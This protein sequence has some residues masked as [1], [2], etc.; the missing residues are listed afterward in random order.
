MILSCPFKKNDHV[1][2]LVILLWVFVKYFLWVFSK[3]S[4]PPAI[5]RM[6]LSA[7]LLSW[8]QSSTA[9]SKFPVS[10]ACVMSPSTSNRRPN[11]TLFRGIFI[12]TT[13]YKA[14]VLVIKH[15]AEKLNCYL[16]WCWDWCPF[17]LEL[18]LE[19][20]WALLVLEPKSY[21]QSPP[22]L[23]LCPVTPRKKIISYS[24]FFYFSCML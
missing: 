17:R 6:M 14:F 13:H 20:Q 18:E 22:L 1:L 2:T 21:Q 4:G 5:A 10:R 19:F 23:S 9:P 3:S 16:D 15:A 24:T 7:I 8:R 12:T 11:F